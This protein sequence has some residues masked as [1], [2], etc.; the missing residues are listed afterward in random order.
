MPSFLKGFIVPLIIPTPEYAAASEIL[1]LVNALFD[2]A[3]YANNRIAKLLAQDG[4]AAA[5]GD[6]ATVVLAFLD[7]ATLMANTAK[8]GTTDTVV[9]AAVVAHVRSLVTASAAPPPPAAAPGTGNFVSG[10]RDGHETLFRGGPLISQCP[11]AR[12]ASTAS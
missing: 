6:N 2:Q 9:V 10:V 7:A 11:R 1:R 8:P 12:C 3:A 4:V 5:L